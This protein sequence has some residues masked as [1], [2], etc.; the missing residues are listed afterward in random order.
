M[1][2]AMAERG[3]SAWVK[4]ESAGGVVVREVDGGRE[5]LAIKPA[6]HERWQLPKG[7]IDFGETAEQA[8]VREVRE[9]GGVTAR[10]EASLP[11]IRYFFQHRRQ[12]IAKVVYYFLMRYES[13]DPGDHDDEV[14]EARWFPLSEPDR[15]TFENE[16]ELVRRSTEIIENDNDGEETS[17]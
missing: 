15:L 11:P 12:K 5:Y 8:A 17:S 1:M 7:R 3:K 14:A 16:H 6:G 13:G 9:E 10:I 2:I 4:Q